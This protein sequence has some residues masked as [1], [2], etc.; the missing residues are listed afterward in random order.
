[1]KKIGAL[2][3]QGK[4]L[5]FCKMFYEVMYFLFISDRKRMS[6]IENEVKMCVSVVCESCHSDFSGDTLMLP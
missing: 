5:P 6:S 1:M 3:E 2:A 4:V